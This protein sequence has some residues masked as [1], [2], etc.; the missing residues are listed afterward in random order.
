MKDK[1]IL[2][3]E[4]S[5]SICGASI[6]LNDELLSIEEKNTN[7]QHAELIPDLTKNSLKNINKTLDDINAIAISIGPGSFTGL[8]VG[9]G[10]AKGIAYAK[11]LPIIP[12]SSLLSLAYSLKSERPTQGILFSHSRKVFY[13][14]FQWKNNIP[15]INSEVLVSEI[16]DFVPILN[17]GFQFNCENLL[18][19]AKRL[20]TATLSSSNIGKLGSIYF[21]DWMVE[22]PH[23]LVPNYIS[24]FK[25]K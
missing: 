25:I 14:T 10:F 21:H 4:T 16:D 13:Q 7:R 15:K 24:P 17:H 8:R 3:L 23:E 2:A 6:L 18:G 12:V 20:K 22:I 1:F 11:S 19:D 9:L 5:S